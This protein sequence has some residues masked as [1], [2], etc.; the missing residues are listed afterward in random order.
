MKKLLRNLT[1]PCNALEFVIIAAGVQQ[2]ASAAGQV[3]LNTTI[4][5]KLHS[6]L[7]LS[8]NLSWIYLF[9]YLKCL[10]I[11]LVSIYS[12]ILCLSIS[13]SIYLVH[14]NISVRPP[15][16]CSTRNQTKHHNCD[17]KL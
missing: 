8:I 12:S 6:I 17:L 3:N 10:S 7:C 1:L 13:A 11:Y 14:G 9:I 5:V 15:G 4:L 16:G 2:E